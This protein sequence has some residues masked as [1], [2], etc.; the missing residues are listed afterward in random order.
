MQRNVGKTDK[1]IRIVIGLGIIIAGIYLKSWW[2]AVGI[3]PIITA[4]IGW[5]AAYVPLGIS[6]CGKKSDCP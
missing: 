2:G 4:A 3:V 6:S 5:C 1:I